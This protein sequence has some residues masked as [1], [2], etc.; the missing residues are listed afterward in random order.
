M[1]RNPRAN[2]NDD[3]KIITVLPGGNLTLKDAAAVLSYTANG[4][5][6]WVARGAPHT[7]GRAGGQA[8]T[9][10][11]RDLMEW[12]VA[13]AV[14]GMMADDGEE[15]NE[16]RAKAAYAHYRAI[17]AEADVRR[18]LGALVAVDMI[19]DVIEEDYQRVRSRL[20]SVAGRVAVRAAAETDASIVRTMISKEIN[21]ALAN[22]AEADD[23]T[24]RAAGNPNASVHDVLMIGG[25]EHGAFDEYEDDLDVN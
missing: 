19:A 15:H 4:L 22:M 20:N 16:G 17:R 8:M 25:G 13:T 18:E 9:V 1:A 5:R 2:A 11:I 23:I 6:D 24:E 21:A 7:P 12:K 10:N 3:D 14:E